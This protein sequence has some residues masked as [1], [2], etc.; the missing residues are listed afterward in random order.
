MNEFVEFFVGLGL[1]LYYCLESIVKFIVPASFR[2]KNVKGQTVLITGAGSGLG[3]LMAERFARLGC[4]LVLWDINGEWNEQTAGIVRDLGAVA[5]AYTC[6]L[7]KRDVVYQ[8]ANKVK[9]E[10]GDVDIL[11]NNAGIVTGKKMLDCSDALMQKTVDVN[12]VAHFWTTKAFIP[13]MLAKNRGH[14]VTI[15]SSAGLFGINGLVDYCASKFAA[16]GFDES[17]RA[18][19]Y[20]SKKTGVHTTVVCPTYI[21][22]GMFDGVKVRFPSLLPIL[23]P[24]YVADKIVEAVLT[25]QTMLILPRI[26]YFILAMKN[27]LPTKAVDATGDFLGL[28]HSQDEYTGRTN[29]QD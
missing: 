21:D 20:A 22:T 13:S 17:L 27:L 28:S 29:K 4:K 5:Y 12:V 9:S 15:A 26:S 7:S 3:R 1:T 19:L 25:N 23:K 10:V 14:I 11:I 6:D 18:E 24:E 8:T 2:S 16:V